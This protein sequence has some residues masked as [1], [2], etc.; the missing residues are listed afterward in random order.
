MILVLALSMGVESS[1]DIDPAAAAEV[2]ATNPG[3]TI[4]SRLV[5]GR[6]RRR[7]CAAVVG[8]S[9]PFAVSPLLCTTSPVSVSLN[10][11]TSHRS[12]S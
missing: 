2:A 12:D 3:L 7:L 9:S 6:A 11:L 4:S 5:R 8:A 1:A 10:V